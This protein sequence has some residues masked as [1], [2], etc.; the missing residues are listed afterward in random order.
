MTTGPVNSNPQVNTQYQTQPDD[1]VNQVGTQATSGSGDGEGVQVSHATPPG[2]GAPPP[3]GHDIDDPAGPVTP[4]QN[5]ALRELFTAD[6]TPSLDF[7]SLM[8]DLVDKLKHSLGA[9]KAQ[10]HA[11]MMQFRLDQHDLAY[12]AAN[13]EKDLGKAAMAWSIISGVSQVAVGGVAMGVGYVTEDTGMTQAA[14]QIGGGLTAP[15]GGGEKLV[16]SNI[17]SRQEKHQADAQMAGELSQDMSGQDIKDAIK[18][19]LQHYGHVA[20]KADQTRE[21]II[22]SFRR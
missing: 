6:L 18:D 17:K 16:E 19:L 3:P 20:D 13:D 11:A 21:S 15:L 5:E 2:S 7:V 10:D 22:G 1:G 14:S 12:D 4:G 8:G 9:E